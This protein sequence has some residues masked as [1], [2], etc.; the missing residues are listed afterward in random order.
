ML[1]NIILISKNISYK[2]L[3]YNKKASIYVFFENKKIIYQPIF[4]YNK[5]FLSKYMLN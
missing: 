5:L 4:I 1:I 3:I 2:I